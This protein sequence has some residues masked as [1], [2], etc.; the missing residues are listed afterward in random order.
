MRSLVRNSAPQEEDGAD[1]P[2]HDAVWLY[3]YADLI[4]QLLLFVISM[5]TAIGI[6]GLDPTL[7]GG[8]KDAAS[9]GKT[10]RELESYV[11]EK[12]LEKAMSIDSSADRLVVRLT[13]VLLFQP[14]QA[15]L[16]TKARG[17]LSDVSS[18]L[19]HIG[20]NI[21]VEGHTD[22]VAIH[23]ASF[24]SNW[25]L[26]TGRAIAVVRYLEEHGIAHG[27]LSAAGYGEYHPIVGNDSDESRALNR[28]VELVILGK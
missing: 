9:L 22:D 3:S 2:L 7:T 28:R 19:D 25:E 5:V 23:T 26:S 18:L 8:K 1:N 17:V 13:S 16:T 15:T 27:R 11:K 14:G 20:N 24:P 4:T 12:N 21:R 10:R 6:S